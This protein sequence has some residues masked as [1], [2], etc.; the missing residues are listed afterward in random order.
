M[1]SIGETM[2]AGIKRADIT[3]CVVCE[4]GLMHDGNLQFYRVKISSYIADARAIQQQAGLEQMM[5]DPTLAQIMGP[6]KD[7]AKE[8]Y[9]HE[10]LICFDCA[11]ESRVLSLL[12]TM[13]EKQQEKED[14]ES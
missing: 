1:R 12:E 8:V 13:S 4:K 5:G 10:A 6:D 9:S 3:N 7:L 14:A 2:S 11:A